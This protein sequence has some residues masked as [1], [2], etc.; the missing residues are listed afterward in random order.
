[1]THKLAPWV[2]TVFIETL[3]PILFIKRPKK[4][5]DDNEECILTDVIHIPMPDPFNM[6]EKPTFESFD[7]GE[8][9]DK[10][11]YA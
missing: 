9:V 7:L 6:Y 4:D 8:Y 3:P 1:M 10:N 11:V 5:D 2:R